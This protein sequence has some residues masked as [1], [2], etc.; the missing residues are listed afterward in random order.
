MS[1]YVTPSHDR[2]WL[3]QNINALLGGIGIALAMLLAVQFL[4][5]DEILGT[6]ILGVSFV[7]A[8]LTTLADRLNSHKRYTRFIFFA[9][10]LSWEWFIMAIPVLV[11]FATHN[12]LS[13]IGWFWF[14]Y[15]TPATIIVNSALSWSNTGHHTWLN[16]LGGTALATIVAFFYTV[17]FQVISGIEVESHMTVILSIFA[18]LHYVSGWLLMGR[19]NLRFDYT[20]DTLRYWGFRINEMQIPDRITRPTKRK[21]QWGLLAIAAVFWAYAVHPTTPTGVI[22]IWVNVWFGIMIARA[23]DY[24]YRNQIQDHLMT[25]FTSLLITM[26]IGMIAYLFVFD[27][28][29]LV[30]GYWAAVVIPAFF[31]F[32]FLYAWEAEPPDEW[33]PEGWKLAAICSIV[34]VTIAEV[35]IHGVVSELWGTYPWIWYAIGGIVAGITHFYIGWR[36][37]D[38]PH[39]P[40]EPAITKIVRLIVGSDDIVYVVI[41]LMIALYVAELWWSTVTIHTFFWAL[42]CMTTALVLWQSMSLEVQMRH[43]WKMS[44]Y[45][46][47]LTSY[48]CMTTVLSA[49]VIVYPSAVT[50]FYMT[51]LATLSL[52]TGLGWYYTIRFGWGMM[53]RGKHIYVSY[54]ETYVVNPWWLRF[55]GALMFGIALAYCILQL[56]IWRSDMSLIARISL[57]IVATIIFA[58]N[59]FAVYELFSFAYLFDD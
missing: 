8:Y 10:F 29:N 53:F 11:G 46:R 24:L 49:F 34:F 55:A 18:V 44:S 28:F 22:V 42:I 7:F 30:T 2:L 41:R 37:A 51:A 3:Q 20:W 31:G 1:T 12:S 26:G 16:A 23:Y 45:T 17:G 47:L 5:G 58:V 40:F 15:L 36:L 50:I 52:L 43:Q 38:R 19:P 56:D 57:Y 48:L 27:G 33:M 59:H 25:L 39:V 32:Y 54:V 4:G 21:I 6:M 14:V 13:P 35:A 9:T